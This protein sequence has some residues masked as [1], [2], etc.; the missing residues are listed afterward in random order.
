MGIS[1]LAFHRLRTARDLHEQVVDFFTLLYTQLRA[2]SIKCEKVCSVND[3]AR[4][5]F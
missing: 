4:G 5:R 3:E 1:L 2:F